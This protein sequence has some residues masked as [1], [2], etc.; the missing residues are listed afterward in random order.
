MKKFFFFVLLLIGT[1]AIAQQGTQSV[2]QALQS[3]NT[4][5]QN[6]IVIIKRWAYWIIGIAFL[7]YAATAV[8]GGNEGG[9]KTKKIGTWFMLIGFIGIAFLIVTAVFGI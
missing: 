9:D 7:I 5:V 2:E 8:L 4:S 1:C 6:I 3:S